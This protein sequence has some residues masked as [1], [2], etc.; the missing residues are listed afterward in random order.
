MNINIQVTDEHVRVEGSGFVTYSPL[1]PPVSEPTPE[2]TPEPTRYFIEIGRNDSPAL[3][4]QRHGRAPE[5]ATSLGDTEGPWSRSNEYTA[6]LLCNWSNATKL[7][8][9]AEGFARKAYPEHFDRE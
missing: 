9:V 4:R 6:D 8:E 1:R 5:F 3:Y 2:P 7:E